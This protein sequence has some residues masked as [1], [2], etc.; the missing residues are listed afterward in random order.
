MTEPLI[1]PLAGGVRAARA[2]SR[3]ALDRRAPTATLG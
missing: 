3:R 2:L 1:L